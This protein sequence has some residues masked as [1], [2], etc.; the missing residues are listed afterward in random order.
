MATL[1]PGCFEEEVSTGGEPC[2]TC[3]WSGEQDR[4][5][6]ALPVQTELKGRYQAG[7]VLGEP[8]G[9]GV[10][11]LGYDRLQNEKVAI[12]EYFPREVAGRDTDGRSVVPHS[13]RG[14][15]EFAYGKEQFLGEAQ[16][17]AQFDHANIV[18]VR[19][20]FEANGTAYLVMDYYEG[21]PLEAYLEEQPDG[22]MEPG[23]AT[24][25]M[26]RILDGLKEMHREGYLHRDIKPENVYLTK[27]GR[28]IL[29][30]FGAARQA[31]GERSQS[32]SV[33]MT[34]GYAPYEQ[35]RRN[36]DQGPYTD[37]YGAGATLYRMM[38]GEKPLPA[39]DRV[40][41]DTLQSPR[42]VNPEVPEG[43]S[44]AVMGAL[45][46]GNK[47][48]L[49]TAER[50]QVRLQGREEE[51][52]GTFQKE[53]GQRDTGQRDTGQQKSRREGGQS[54]EKT[55]SESDGKS[56]VGGSSFR[57]RKRDDGRTEFSESK[58]GRLNNKSENVN[59][60][61]TR[62]NLAGKNARSNSQKEFP[63]KKVIKY[64]SILVIIVIILNWYLS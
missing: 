29:I 42:E 54:S 47:E 53:S 57:V 9:F 5:P 62:P 8:G 52:G 24:E 16:T 30:D 31:V 58:S 1:C 21:K 15:E 18:S 28:P 20:F 7:R 48:R 55:P 49:A 64:S 26:L 33:V 12:K 6:L 22:C 38:T 34:P 44:R 11:Y 56:N 61:N 3:G 35:Y 46:V 59:I 51:S 4:P 41:E 43:L 39:T 40:V 37:V 45:A 50:L 63:V 60:K 32:L 27:E 10:T 14:D 17:L 19:D 36:G 25:V 23:A 2:P 13:G